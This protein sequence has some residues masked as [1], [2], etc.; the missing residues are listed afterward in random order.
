MMKIYIKMLLF[1]FNNTIKVFILNLYKPKVYI[2]WSPGIRRGYGNFGD[3]ITPYLAKSL[4]YAA[5]WVPPYF[6][7][8]IGAGSLLSK[9]STTRG[10]ILGAGSLSDAYEFP[11]NR[12]VVCVRGKLTLNKLNADRAR[13]ISLGDPG[14][15]LPLVYEKKI[16]SADKI[17]VVP[18]YTQLHHPDVANLK[19]MGLEVISPIGSVN[20]VV[21]KIAECK[22]IVSSSL[23]GL[24]LAHAFNKKVVWVAFGALPKGGEYKF[25]DF[26]SAFDDASMPCYLGSELDSIEKIER[27]A[28][29]RP[30]DFLQVQKKLW[31]SHKVFFDK[32]HR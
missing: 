9:F 23:H 10:T 4:G 30:S 2:F 21:S 24:I 5:V 17:G 14:I 22:I 7:Q 28:Q 32:L 6:A 8:V 11:K 12:S 20:D 3:L 29:E 27:I 1:L 19:S 15:L 31:E 16:K 25:L 26:L 18:H 13:S